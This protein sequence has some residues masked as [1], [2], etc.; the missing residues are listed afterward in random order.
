VEAAHDGGE[1][2]RTMSAFRHPESAKRDEGPQDTTQ[3]AISRSF[4]VYAAQDDGM[5]THGEDSR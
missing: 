3:A 1:S 2:K 4:A 5:E